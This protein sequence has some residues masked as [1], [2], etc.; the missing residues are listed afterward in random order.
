[1]ANPGQPASHRN[2]TED[3]TGFSG[4][5][6]PIAVV[7]DEEDIAGL[8]G[9]H[10]EKAGFRA[11]LFH[12][13]AGFLAWLGGH[14]PALVILDIML[15]DIQGT[16]LCRTIRSSERLNAVPVIMLT[17]LGH[18]TEKVLGLELGADD[19]M[20][21]P[22][23]PRELVARV[24]AVLR[25]SRVKADTPRELRWG[26][27]VLRPASF[28]ALR[29]GSPMLLTPTEFR[30]LLAL[31]EGNGR[32]LSRSSLLDLLWEGEKFVFER[33][34]DVHIAHIREKLGD[35]G[36]LLNS[37]RGIGYRMVN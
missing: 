34:I 1:M 36:N 8:V 32:V 4:P 12:D 28:E 3:L 10:L 31:V 17:A 27:I 15:P 7:E 18:E 16:D 6:G 23:S 26:P 24:R 35:A 25:R 21:K 13:G 29:G 5:E 19:Y 37:V 20:V 2:P 11:L 33:T 30:I 14:L 22:F 9:M